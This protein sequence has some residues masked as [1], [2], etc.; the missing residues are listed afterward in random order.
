[1]RKLTTGE[2]A[3][4]SITPNAE[5]NRV[6]CVH[7]VKPDKDAPARYELKWTFDFSNVT[8]AELLGLAARTVL[9]AMQSTWR[10]ASDKERV[11]A[12]TWHDV[13]FKVRDMLD[14]KRQ[15]AS[16]AAKVAKAAKTMD[17]SELADTIKQ[18][19]AMQKEMA[20]KK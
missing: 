4:R 8:P 18:L 20:D 1:M 7:T 11:D 12:K 9:I 10:G 2:E 13:T 5:K 19:E 14:N 15:A 16:P 17:A 3:K 6:V